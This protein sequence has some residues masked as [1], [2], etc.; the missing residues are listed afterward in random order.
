MLASQ[1]KQLWVAGVAQLL[2]M[3]AHAG[4]GGM[5]NIDA[6]GGV[7]GDGFS[8]VTSCA[9]T[10]AVIGWLYAKHA[11]SG[12][13]EPEQVD[14]GGFSLIGGFAGA[15]VLPFVWVLLTR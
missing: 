12:R 5:G 8:I 14:P 7:S 2:S 13:P 3:R 4:F 9:I 1:L 15:F 6:D 10:G 11:N